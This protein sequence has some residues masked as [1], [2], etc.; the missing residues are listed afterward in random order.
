MRNAYQ[1]TLT[2]GLGSTIILSS[3]LLPQIAHATPYEEFTLTGGIN[4]PSLNDSING[5]L[6]GTFTTDLDSPSFNESSSP[7]FSSIEYN[8]TDWDITYTSVSG[9]VTHFISDGIGADSAYLKLL[10]GYDGLT[11]G[12]DRLSITFFEN[13]AETKLELNF[14]TD[15]NIETS[16]T[17]TE[18]LEA[19]SWVGTADSRS[20]SS[21]TF[22]PSSSVQHLTTGAFV[23]AEPMAEAVSPVPE[24]STLALL[25]L[26]SLIMF[27]AARRAKKKQQLVTK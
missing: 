1:K 9:D 18:L 8:I 14:S 16:T 6:S 26:G 22:T 17:L 27:G 25:G 21:I 23:I 20:T 15:Y 5:S 3:F 2:I 19:D 4:N 12:S 13:N 24:P 11:P 7:I 10:P